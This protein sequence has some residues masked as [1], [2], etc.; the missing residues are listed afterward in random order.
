ME[1][2]F[3]SDRLVQLSIGSVINVIDEHGSHHSVSLVG[4]G[5]GQCVITLLPTECTLTEGDELEMQTIHDGHVIAFESSVHQIFENRLLICTFPEMIE[6]RRLRQEVRFPCVLSC[7]IHYDGK[8][9]YGAVTNI[10]TGGC[11]L[12]VSENAELFE[13]ALIEG[14]TIDIDLILP[15]SEIPIELSGR[16]KSTAQKVDES[17]IIGISFDQHYDDIRHYLDSLHLDSITPFFK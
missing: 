10:S 8:E 16:V 15:Y 4:V 7:D 5:V 6:S 3:S 1:E 13:I 17:Y 2:Y 11:Q 9:T 14:G 12:N